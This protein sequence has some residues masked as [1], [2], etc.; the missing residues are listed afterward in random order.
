[1]KFNAQHDARAYQD[2]HPPQIRLQQTA[3]SPQGRRVVWALLLFLAFLL[4]WALLGRLDIVAVADGKLVPA[5]YLQ[6]VQP[7]EAGIVKEILVREGE[8][9]AAG[10]VLMRM[11]PLITEA[12]LGAVA[13]EHMRQRLQLARI[14][15]ELTGGLL[16][17]P[18]DAPSGLVQEVKTKYQAN[19]AA[20]AT[21]LAEERARLARTQQELAA[22][23]QQKARL[24]AVLPHY[25]AQDKAYEQL[26]KDGFAGAL[27]G[28][29]KRRQRIE[30]EQELATQVHLVAAALAGIVQSQ[31][32]LRQIEAD[33]LRSLHVERV[34][35]QSQLNNLAME[36]EK[37]Q[38][39]RALLEL[40]APREGAIK[41]LATHTV[42]TVVQP[43]TVLASLVPQEDRL[44]VEVWVS[45]ADIGFVRVG[46]AVKLKFAAYP[47]QRYGM[48]HGTVEH[49]GADAM[50]EQ[51]AR[52][53][54]LSSHN[55]QPL[56]FR[57]LVKLESPMLEMNGRQ[58]ALTAGMQTTAEILLG[59]R[60][61]AQYLLSPVLRAWHE[62]ARER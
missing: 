46:Q 33:Y 24:E 31:A 19:R 9:V 34:Q 4:L 59:Q 41:D 16:V 7:S 42:G 17:A 22:A 36:L 13:T 62:A 18:K 21:T 1:M 38:H 5:N 39:R 35:V 45:N 15:A 51:A 8:R 32:K 10:Q 48:G 23:R 43:G 2:F 37:L 14:D 52:D 29:D 54:G 49:I 3:P 11:D 56:R 28:G 25:L 26:V 6:I 50:T 60:T 47:F 58:F 30:K 27:M 53:A 61:V 12:E 57:A 44:K 55:A 20:L 40:K